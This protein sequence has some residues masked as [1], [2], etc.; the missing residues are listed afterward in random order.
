MLKREFKYTDFNGVERKETCYFNLNKQEIL[1]MQLTT[2][3]SLTAILQRIVD[4]NDN[5]KLANFFK[6]IIL[7]SYGVKTD[8]GRMFIKNDKVREEF[9]YT[10]MYEELYIELSTDAE[11]AVKFVKG[12]MPSDLVAEAG[13]EIIALEQ[14]MIGSTKE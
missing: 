12:I 6:E 8:D 9:T 3:G 1:E 11:K 5:V 13:A 14:K 10:P 2:E 7:K 4:A